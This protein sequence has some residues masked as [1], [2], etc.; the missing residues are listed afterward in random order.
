MQ[1]KLVILTIC[2]SLAAIGFATPSP[3]ADGLDSITLSDEQTPPGFAIDDLDSLG[4][5][6]ED[7]GDPIL[8][9]LD[10]ALVRRRIPGGIRRIMRLRGGR[11]GRG[12][13]GRRRRGRI[14]RRIRKAQRELKKKE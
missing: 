13:G 1:I 11:R 12:R 4:G 9:N 6:D 2:A 7:I 14:G 8:G 5:I 10:E 3:Q